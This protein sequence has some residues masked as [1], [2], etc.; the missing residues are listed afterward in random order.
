[1]FVS[2]CMSHSSIELRG[3]NFIDESSFQFQNESIC[4]SRKQVESA[5]AKGIKS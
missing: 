4:E 5:H 1:V 3:Q 2:V